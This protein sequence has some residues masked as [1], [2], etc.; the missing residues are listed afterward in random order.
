MRA[1]GEARKQGSWYQSDVGQ[2]ALEFEEEMDR[3]LAKRAAPK[4]RA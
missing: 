2:L 1:F 4:K 3:K